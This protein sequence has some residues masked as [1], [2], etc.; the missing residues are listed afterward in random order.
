MPSSYTQQGYPEGV[1][2][3]E[4]VSGGPADEAG[5]EAGDIITSMDGTA[6]STKEA[7]TGLLK[8]YAAGEEIEI[9]L[10]R[11]KSDRSGFEKVKCTVTLGNKADMPSQT[12]ST[13]TDEAEENGNDS[14]GG[15]S[16]ESPFGDNDLYRYF[17]GNGN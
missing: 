13:N 10:S 2:V 14:D 12:E 8:Y 11:I 1:Y 4:V 15:G 3:T 5:I 7:L 9:S 16:Q 6:V 17:F